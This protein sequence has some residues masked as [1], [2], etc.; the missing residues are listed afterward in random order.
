MAPTM[1]AAE[2]KR[3]VVKCGNARCSLMQ[4][5]TENNLC[6]RCAKALPGGDPVSQEEPQVVAPV[7]QTTNEKYGLIGRLPGV[8]R[9]LRLQSGFPTVSGLSRSMGFPRNFIPRLEGGVDSPR[10]ATLE[11]LSVPYRTNVSEII[12]LAADPK[13]RPSGKFRNVRDGIGLRIPQVF[14]SRA[15]TLGLGAVALAN[16]LGVSPTY[17]HHV[18]S[19][20][21]GP[22]RLSSL[23]VWAAALE[24]TVYEIVLCAEEATDFLR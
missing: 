15:S 10:I 4:F 23:E 8:L 21:K 14:A 16:R 13:A 2:V 1:L 5:R 7:T 12:L 17:V 24:T 20:M 9:Q 18:K 22:P 19:G 11:K 3:E 6:R